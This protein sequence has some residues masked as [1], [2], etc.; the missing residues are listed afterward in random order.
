MLASPD[1]I[2]LAMLLLGAVGSFVGGLIVGTWTVS[3]K[4]HLLADLDKRVSRLEGC[5]ERKLDRLHERIDALMILAGE[6]PAK[7][8]RDGRER[9]HGY[10]PA[11]D[12]DPEKRDYYG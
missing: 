11:D 4:L 6:D 12:G 3:A 9:A 5:I 7:V 10:R 1:E 2:N 8:R